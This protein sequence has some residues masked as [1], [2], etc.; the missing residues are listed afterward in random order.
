MRVLVLGATG[1]LGS[2]VFKYFSQLP[3]ISTFG[4]V[5]SRGAFKYFDD[6]AASH[7]YTDVDVLDHDALVQVL[8]RARPNVVINCIGLIKQFSDAKDPLRALPINS[9]LPH[10]LANICELINARLIHVS[11][12]CVF[13]GR[14]GMYTE[15]D[16]SD[17]EDLYGKS[18]YIGEVTDRSHVL[19][20]RTSIIGHELSSNASLVDW[21][22][23][24]QGIVKGFTKAIFSGLT[25]LEVARVLKEFV[26]PA[27]QLHGLYHLSVNPIDKYSL[28]CEVAKVYGK[29]ITIVPD[30]ALEIDRSLDSS[31]FRAAV[32]YTPPSWPELIQ[33][34]FLQK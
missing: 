11:T 33:A 6:E 2:T 28:L 8:S 5:R 12:D 23:S 32:G 26:L 14:K 1:M 27:P 7:L 17:A 25:T 16:V 10:R 3:N 21:F 18:K 20:L 4:T 22:L 24:Q 30:S 13:S 31:R 9:M 15:D 34:M 29:D 19:T